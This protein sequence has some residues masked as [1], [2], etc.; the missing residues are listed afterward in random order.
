LIPKKM[1]DHYHH[2][3]V[4]RERTSCLVNCTSFLFC[5]RRSS[6]RSLSKI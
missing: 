5:F 6:N 1:Y 4:Q 3:D 2:K